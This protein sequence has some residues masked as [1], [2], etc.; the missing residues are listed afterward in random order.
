MI[1]LNQPVGKRGSVYERERE[2]ER[3]GIAF[4]GRACVVYKQISRYIYEHV[5]ISP[6]YI[7]LNVF[8]Y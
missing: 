7:I 1:D 2:R 3:E 5:Y 8:V 6:I 4:I